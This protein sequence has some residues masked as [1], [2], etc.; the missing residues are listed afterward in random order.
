MWVK[1][2]HSGVP[3][4]AQWVKNPN[5]IHKDEGS[6]PGLAQWVNILLVHIGLIISL[7]SFT[8]IAFIKY[9]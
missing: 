5:S 8:L 7:N 3:V 1:D 2:A 6:I 9:L 4:V